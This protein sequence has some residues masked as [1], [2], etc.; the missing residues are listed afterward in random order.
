MYHRTSKV[1]NFKTWQFYSAS[2][3]ILGMETLTGL[4]KRSI[5]Q[6]QRWSADP[7]TTESHQNNPVDRIEVLLEK[8]MELGRDDVAIVPVQRMASIVGMRL[9][10][11]NEPAPDKDTIA[12]ELNDNIPALGR[13]NDMVTAAKNGKASLDEVYQARREL[14]DEIDQDIVLLKQKRGM[15]CQQQKQM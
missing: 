9:V 6:I 3:R 10:P 12:D 13:Y 2:I 7:R 11:V 5:R 14:V 4:Y 15:Q 8:L 1:P